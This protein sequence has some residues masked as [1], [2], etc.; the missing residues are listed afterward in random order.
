MK[1]RL[2]LLILAALLGLSGCSGTNGVSSSAPSSSSSAADSSLSSSEAAVQD[3]ANEIY[4]KKDLNDQ[5]TE[6]DCTLIALSDSPV[7]TGSGAEADGQVVRITAGGDY[8]LSGSFTGQIVVDAGKKDDVRLILNGAEITSPDSAALWVKQAD[9]VILTLAAGSENTLADS[10]SRADSDESDAAV[11]AEDDLSINGS[12]SLNISGLYHHGV[13]T[14]NDLTI[15]GGQLAVT[16]AAD[17]LKGKDS[18][19]VL[20]G[21]ITITADGDGIQ[22]SETDDAAKGWVRIDGGSLAITAA[23]DG[24]QAETDLFIADGSV[25]LLTGGG[26]YA[27]GNKADSQSDRFGGFGG[28]GFGGGQGFEG[29]TPPDGSWPQRPEGSRGEG[30]KPSDGAAPD[31]SMTPPEGFTPPEGEEPPAL[32]EGFA[33][34]NVFGDSEADEETEPSVSSKGLKAGRQ[35]EISGGSVM[36]DSLDD[37]IHS[38]GSVL[39]S[40]GVLSLSSGDDGIHADEALT[41]SGGEIIVSRSYEGL[42]GKTVDISAGKVQ[43]TASDDGINAADGTA[44]PF[45]QGNDAVSLTISGGEVVVDA[46]GDGLDS[47]GALNLDGGVVLVSGPVNA[48]NGA[49]DSDGKCSLSGGVLWAAGSAGMDQAP[50]EAAQPVLH[51]TFSESQPAGSVIVLADES[52]S[53]IAAFTAAKAFN[54]LVVSLEGLKAGENCQLII[55]GTADGDWIGS[56]ETRYCASP[57]LSGG[58]VKESFTVNE[59]VNRITV[60]K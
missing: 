35:L 9:K 49:L 38:N 10:A 11:Y 7:V 16:A 1:K 54:S 58:E 21:E 3:A 33:P 40:G 24:I 18:V 2:L 46:S 45:G 47:N 36:A 26:S 4:S 34:E 6:K 19:A 20:G 57:T 12:G 43:I 23:E 22:S 41:V 8:L 14:K 15:T 29:Q 5:W 30:R 50:A 37:T 42:E 53:P 51:F 48:G 32:P 13:H 56:G 27:E 25:T 28:R 44:Q 55:G 52:G 60:S 59:G 31:S 39:V 17:G